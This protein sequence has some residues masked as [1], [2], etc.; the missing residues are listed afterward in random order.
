MAKYDVLDAGVPVT[1][2]SAN[3]YKKSAVDGSLSVIADLGTLATDEIGFIGHPTAIH[4]ILLA[5]RN[6][7]VLDEKKMDYSAALAAVT[8]TNTGDEIEEYASSTGFPGTGSIGI[9]Y[10]AQDTNSLYRWDGASYQSMGGG[11]GGVFGVDYGPVTVGLS[12]THWRFRMDSRLPSV[13][14]PYQ[15][16]FD[17]NLWSDALAT[18]PIS[19][20]GATASGSGAI[21]TGSYANILDNTTTTHARFEYTDGCYVTIVLA[22]PATVRTMSVLTSEG[23]TGG[24][25]NGGITGYTIQ[26]SIDNG[27]TWFQVD[28]VEGPEFA[29]SPTANDL[30]IPL[31]TYPVAP[32]R[33]QLFFNDTTNILMLW[34]GVA[35]VD[36]ENIDVLEFA[37]LAGFPTT[38]TAGIIYIAQDTN[39][40]YRWDGAAYVSV[41]GFADALPTTAEINAQTGT[42]YTLLAADNGKIVTC[43]NAAAITVTVPSGLGAGFN[44]KVIQ[45][46]AG[47]V[48][49][50]GSGATINNVN[51][52]TGTAGQF[53][54]ASLLAYAADTFLMQGDTA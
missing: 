33:G 26:A 1:L 44:C 45:I 42:T 11:I 38:G 25:T 18:V 5:D 37:N 2:N 49:I 34:D 54:A 48:T 36:V 16:I 28:Q 20:V 41:G 6:I 9:V 51:S 30:V 53:G 14:Y 10:I 19:L 35:W 3:N 24:G 40:L 50:T 12:T 7:S 8:G 32:T 4:K 31:V 29:E 43:D 39:N 17:I 13:T 46:G 27:S 21:F 47:I 15:F 52:H 22:S 23:G